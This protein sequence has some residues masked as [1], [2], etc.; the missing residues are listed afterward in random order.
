VPAVA[1]QVVD[2]VGNDHAGGPTGKSWSNA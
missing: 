2:A 1:G